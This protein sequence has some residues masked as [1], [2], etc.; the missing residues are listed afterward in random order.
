MLSRSRFLIAAMALAAALLPSCLRAD[1]PHRLRDEDKI[2]LLRSLMAEYATAKILIPRS[3][4]ALTV[5]QDGRYNPQ[6]WQTAGDK[7]GIAARAGD[8]VQF[9]K[10]NIADNRIEFELNGGLGGRKW[11][12]GLEIGMGSSGRTMPVANQGLNVAGGTKMALR[13]DKNDPPRTIEEVKDLLSDIFD[14]NQRSAAEQYME[15]LSPE[16]KQAIEE[17]KAIKGMDREQVMLA[18]GKPVRK[19]RES[20]DGIEIEDWIYG[21]PPGKITFVSF[22]GNDVIEVREEWAGMGQTAPK[23]NVPH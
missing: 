8:L 11:Y 23:L 16:V 17:K 4:K 22:D 21:Q 13:F 9:T 10:V 12:H 3:K 15:S 20:K 2:V 14:F 6:E 18:L 7:N 19:V 5:E 1:N